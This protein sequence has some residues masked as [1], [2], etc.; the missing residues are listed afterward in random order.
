MTTV[1]GQGPVSPTLQEL[2]EQNRRLQTQV[3]QQQRLIE[4][5]N[6]R[7]NETVRAM[8]RQDQHL[9]ALQ[10]DARPPAAPTLAQGSIRLGGEAGFTFRSSAAG[11]SSPNSA[12]RVDDAKLF[13]EAGL[14]RNATF[15]G[16]M[17][18]T[19]REG[20]DDTG[21]TGEIYVQFEDILSR[22]GKPRALNAK[23]GR[24]DIPFGEE[25]QTRTVM[26]N[27]LVA[28]SVADPW[29][30]DEGV[31]V[32]GTVAG[33]R[34]VLAVQNGG[35]DTIHDF[36][37]DKSI[38][39]RLGYDPTRWLHLSGS[40]MRTGALNSALDKMSAEWIGGGFF[41]PIGPVAPATFDANLYQV[42]A[43]VHGEA[44]SLGLTVGQARYGDSLNY[45][46]HRR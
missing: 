44:G 40:A 45:D 2:A 30:I 13:V 14:W 5:M 18:L 43:K 39:G 25:Y 26:E 33:V 8:E 20:Q 10:S 3:E 4:A 16:G 28:H 11:G 27:P 21:R 46:R 34:Y 17:N 42:D 41:R 36:N 38:A 29:G 6:A 19:T 24:F 32:Y 9:E 12:F 15:F 35:V 37:R 7:L 22:W 23:V 1:H 31:E